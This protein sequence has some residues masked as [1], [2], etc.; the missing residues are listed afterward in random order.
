M[1][2]GLQSYD[3]PFTVKYIWIESY[4]TY[5]CW[6]N[7]GDHN[8]RQC[9]SMEGVTLPMSAWDSGIH[10]GWHENCDC[11][12]APVQVKNVTMVPTIVYTPQPFLISDIMNNK[13]YS[14]VS[15][16]CTPLLVVPYPQT[17]NHDIWIYDVGWAAEH[18]HDAHIQYN[19]PYVEEY[20][21]DPNYRHA[22]RDYLG[23][24]NDPY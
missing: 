18:E 2:P 15:L 5:F 16:M 12:L 22:L 1:F 8:C 6:T 17:P 13:F 23:G 9:A 4:Q 24:Q 11:Y 19:V 10:P 7:T 20:M 14:Q 3:L 21:K